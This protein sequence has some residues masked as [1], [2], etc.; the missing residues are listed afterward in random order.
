MCGIVGYLGNKEAVPVLLRGLKQLEYRGYDSSGIGILHRK[1]IKVVKEEGKLSRLEA[2]ITEKYSS[3]IGIGHTRWATHGGV[4]TENAHPHSGP[5]GKVAIVHNGI[6][7]N[8]AILKKEL[9]AKGN[10][11]H[12]ETDSEVVAHLVESYLEY[13]PEKA[14]SMALDRLDGTYG[15]LI[16]FQEHPDMII[17]A[18]NGSPLVVGVGQNEM[19]LASDAMAFATYTQHAIFIEDGEMV[20]LNSDEYRVVNRQNM[21]IDKSVERLDLDVAGIDKQGFSHFLLKEI[22]EQPESVFRAMGRG[23]RLLPDYGTSLLGGL[24]MDKRDF[25]DIKKIHILAMG[26]AMY[27]GELGKYI[28]E[29]LARIPVEVSDASELCGINPIVDKDT[30]FVAI[31]QSGETRDTIAAVQEIKQKGGR[32]LGILNAVGSTLARM[33]DGGAYIHAGSEISVASTKAFTSQVTVLA[34]LALMI[35]RTRDISLVRGK[36]LVNELMALPDKIRI[37]L[38][39]AEEI[40]AMADELKEHDSVMY[41][42]RGINFPVAMEAA[43][44]LKEVS[45]IHAEAYSA[46]SLKHGPLALISEDIPSV[47][48]CTKGDYQE[49]TISN[50]QEVR[51]RNG[52]VLVISNYEDETL[53][54]VADKLFVVPDSDPLLSPLLTIVPCQ[55]LGYYTALAL[56]RDIDQ[57]RNL[58]KSVT[59][60]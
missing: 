29:D 28:I 35:G 27:A 58:A 9:L 5:E 2:K 51:A 25:Y 37:I 32:V 53:R 16:L 30:I 24:N 12:S 46:G 55:L 39:K 21:Q 20:V 54:R 4:T 45:Y 6:I 42:G 43:L 47:F 1:K 36:E 23:G 44:K 34:L 59:T 50:I 10:I 14:V 8:F 57:P 22:F 11:F 18:R 13:G 40:K 60:D 15:M 41:M 26:T 56:D 19:F 38:E 17:G 49:K 7:D 31:S 3:T 33:T 52:R 48:I